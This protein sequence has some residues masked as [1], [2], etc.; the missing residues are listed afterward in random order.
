MVHIV[1]AFYDLSVRRGLHSPFR[2]IVQ[3]GR[4]ASTRWYTLDIAARPILSAVD[5]GTKF[6]VPM[7][8][9]RNSEAFRVP[10]R[11]YDQ[12]RF[13]LRAFPKGRGEAFWNRF[14]SDAEGAGLPH[15]ARRAKRA[16]ELILQAG[17]VADDEVIRLSSDL[18]TNVGDWVL[19]TLAGEPICEM[20]K[21]R[22]FWSKQFRWRASSTPS[23]TD[24][25]TGE[26]CSP[27]MRCKE[28][29]GGDPKCG[30]CRG[31]GEVP[32]LHR[33]VKVYGA[34]GLVPLVSFDKPAFAYERR[35]GGLN[36]PI[37]YETSEQY[38]AGL[39]Y[40]LNNCC[41]AFGAN[42]SLL[43]WSPDA[44]DEHPIVP[45]MLK[46]FQPWGFETQ[47]E[48][49]AAWKQ[50]EE[51][52]ASDTDR[53]ALLFL[54]GGRGRVSVLN[55]DYVSA[56]STKRALLRFRDEFKALTVMR[57]AVFSH[58]AA[59][60]DTRKG[61][62]GALSAL[63]PQVIWAIATGG[64]YP[65]PVIDQAAYVPSAKDEGAEALA[66]LW[67]RACQARSALRQ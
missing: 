65:L 38:A 17:I 37:A 45:L 5:E 64:P 58:R 54:R 66:M 32:L 49:Q 18:E 15:V 40:L 9:V 25:I 39:S 62:M 59:A 23:H 2:T 57:A 63:F 61:K 20:P 3:P 42:L 53:I 24:V 47:E 4:K 8:V 11:G 43:V 60:I 22:K 7:D 29:D 27:T 51:S 30:K 35:D 55:F 33:K 34:K 13:V 19:L 16:A 46:L 31:R 52:S 56:A 12:A 41:A 14:V 50:I 26:P 1:R 36:F 21:F 44:S 6:S 10:N 28:C 67:R 48:V